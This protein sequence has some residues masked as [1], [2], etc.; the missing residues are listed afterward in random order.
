MITH[1]KHTGANMKQNTKIVVSAKGDPTVI[2]FPEG[3]LKQLSIAAAQNGRSRNSEIVYR[4]VSSLKQ[5]QK[6]AA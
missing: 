6:Q 4:L 2:R 1:Y 5:K 3:I